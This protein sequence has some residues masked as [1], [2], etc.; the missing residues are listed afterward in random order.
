[1][2]ATVKKTTRKKT[3]AMAAKES[4]E[5]AA[6]AGYGDMEDTGFENQT[7]DDYVVPYLAIMQALSPQ[8]EENPDVFRIGQVFNSVTGEVIDG[9]IGVSFVPATTQHLFVEWVPRT[10]GGGF[11]G[12]HM[13]T[14]DVVR[15]ALSSSKEFGKYV[16]PE[17]NT[18][19]E[20]FYVYGLVIDN[21]ENVGQAVISFSGSKIKKYKGWMTK[22]KTIQIKLPDG[23]RIPAPLFS[24]RWRLKTINEKNNKGSFSNWVIGFDG[25]NAQA[26]RLAADS[27]LVSQALAIKELISSG[28]AKTDYDGMGSSG[29]EKPTGD[30]HAAAGGEEKA[31]F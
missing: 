6:F 22:A 8:V 31:K 20:T 25:E 17:G 28:E 7:S 26:C 18:L 12:V 29:G 10:Q 24:H 30:Q 16:T 23:R 19:T 11:V 27:D 5:M 1:M 15:E 4:T 9:K 3:T 2:T 14:S 21:D 13:P